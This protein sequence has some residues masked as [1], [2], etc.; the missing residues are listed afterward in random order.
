MRDVVFWLSGATLAFLISAGAFLLLAN[1]ATAPSEK[2]L[3]PEPASGG[4]GHAVGLRL[5][6]EG[7]ASL[8][9]LPDQSLDLAVENEGAER[10]SDVT[11]VL[12]VSSE[13]TA[14]PDSRLYRHTIE[15]IPVGEVAKVHF[16]FD[17]AAS[18]HPATRPPTQAP[19]PSREILELRATTPEGD[20]TVRTVILPT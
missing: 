20:S 15:K 17:L 2:S 7:L 14:F 10:F 4:S 3:A 13:N 5:D 1:L 16:V 6:R 11:V 9:P 8:R 18:E 12:M 19:E